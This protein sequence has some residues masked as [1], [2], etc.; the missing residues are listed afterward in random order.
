MYSFFFSSVF[1][2]VFKTGY[3]VTA[4]APMWTD[5]RF[6]ALRMGGHALSRHFWYYVPEFSGKGT[7]QTPVIVR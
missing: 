5:Q 1:V 7:V 2:V 6:F 4:L 3:D